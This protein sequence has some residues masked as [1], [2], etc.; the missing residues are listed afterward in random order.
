M[1]VVEE[2][3]RDPPGGGLAPVLLGFAP[4][5]VRLTPDRPPTIT[6]KSGGGAS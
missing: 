4:L 2:V 5:T 1:H 3:S 6:P